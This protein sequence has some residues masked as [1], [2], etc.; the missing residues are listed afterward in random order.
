[1]NK[2]KSYFRVKLR[3]FL[4]IDDI[5]RKIDKLSRIVEYNQKSNVSYHD[6]LRDRINTNTINVNAIHKTSESV[7]H[8]GTDIDRTPCDSHS[9]AVVCIEGKINM[10]KFV[11]LSGRD[12]RDVMDFL[13]NFEAGRHCIDTDTP[14]RH[15]KD[16]LT[17][18]IDS[19]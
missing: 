8:V 13:K 7:V 16:D 11:D 14:F 6:T 19:K 2:L 4:G 5:D 17:F 10:V 3:R 1:M 9:W 15:F 12:A 18:N